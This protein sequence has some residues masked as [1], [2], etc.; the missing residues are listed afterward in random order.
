MD[1]L[2]TRDTGGSDRREMI[3]ELPWLEGASLFASGSA[4]L[5]HLVRWGVR[6]HGWQRVWLPSY[7]CPDVSAALVAAIGREVELRAY[8]DASLWT[9]T[10]QGMVP[11]A[12]GDLVVVANQLGVRPR[13][14]MARLA[15]RAVIVEDHSHDLGSA[16]A[17][18]SRADYAFASL[19]KTLPI[20]DGGAVWSPQG[21]E[22]PPEPAREDQANGHGDPARRPADR[23]AAALDRRGRITA[24]IDDKLRFRAL[25][26]TAAGPAGAVSRGAI[27]PV[28]RALLRHMPVQAWRERRRRNLDVLADAVASVAGTRILRAPAGGVAFA[29]TLVFDV[30]RA[31]QDAQRALVSR[32]VIP[33]VLWPLDP[34]RDWGAGP[35]EA[36]LSSRILSIHGDQRYDDTDMR[37]LA[38]ILRETLGG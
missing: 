24:A 35:A 18:E 11:A 6:R 13:P 16:W 12:A 36:D 30:A 19:R 1:R 9:A 23:L 15:G 32:A 20:A 17:L 4:A 22:L 27:S 10:D 21:R 5:V 37:R 31:R 38:E 25:A 33:T 7:Y 26:R 2:D 34:D 14:D 28:S 3:A 8:P 29:L